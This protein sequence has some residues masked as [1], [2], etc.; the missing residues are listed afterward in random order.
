MATQY[1]NW[2][3]TLNNYNEEE[4]DGLI[5]NELFN[6]VIIGREV[7]TEGTPHLQGYMQLH[8]RCRIT[9]LKNINN[10]V[11]WEPAKGTA[12]QASDYCKKDG[13]FVEKGN[14][15]L[16]G[17]KK[18]NLKEAV[19]DVAARMTTSELL[20]KHGSGYI[21]HKRKIQEVAE[22]LKQEL[23]KRRRFDE[24]Q[25]MSLRDWQKDVL[26]KLEVQS[27]RQILFVMDSEGGKG[28]STLANYMMATLDAVLFENGKST[29]I[30]Y[31]Y[32]GQNYVIFDLCRSCSE[33]INYEVIESL[34]NGRFCSYKYESTFKMFDIPRVV[35]FMNEGPDMTK[36]SYDR[37][38][39]YAL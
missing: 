38:D 29:D 24:I 8:K 17:V 20:D 4:Y 3:F 28:K 27:D 32:K 33:H 5:N 34:K 9:G 31:A 37:Y 18:C 23:V 10:R 1:F 14:M 6:Y 12:I 2:C 21:M 30:K 19:T 11:H 26:A 22:D 39:L 35:V 36:L 25:Q 13:L 7:G 15:T 16:K